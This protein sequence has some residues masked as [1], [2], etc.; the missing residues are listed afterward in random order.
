MFD[1]VQGIE[2]SGRR[3][4][5]TSHLRVF[6]SESPPAR[7]STAG[8]VDDES[9]CF[10]QHG[11]SV[12]ILQDSPNGPDSPNGFRVGPLAAAVERRDDHPHMAYIAP[13]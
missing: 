8:P 13:S 3:R 7:N 4:P 10:L 11:L 6:N 12:M 1:N 2:L 9:P 5:G